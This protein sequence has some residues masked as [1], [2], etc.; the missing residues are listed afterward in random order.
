MG[1]HGVAHSLIRLL[2]RA[3][4]NMQ[5]VLIECLLAV[6]S[7]CDT[8][9]TVV[10]A[11]GGLEIIICLLNTCNTDVRFGMELVRLG[12]L[13][14]IVEASGVGSMIS[15]GSACQSIRLLGV[16]REARHTLVELGVIPVLMELF[17]IGDTAAKLVAGNTL[18]VVVWS[19]VDY[20]RHV[21]EV[22]AIPLYA[23][24]LQG[25]D[26]NDFGKEIAKE[27]F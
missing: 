24:L 27:V 26:P 8:S 14:F 2:P 19:N 21:V 10:A 22:G 15:R 11:N 9:T 1:E 17:H 20:I 6:V 4:G 18:G 23:E 7:F 12:A 5:K 3:E 25:S 16:S 13:C